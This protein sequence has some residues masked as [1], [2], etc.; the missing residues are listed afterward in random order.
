M[1]CFIMFSNDLNDE[2]CS[3]L[4]CFPFDYLSQIGACVLARLNNQ[5]EYIALYDGIFDKVIEL[6]YVSI[7]RH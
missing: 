7:L 1:Q 3:L 4:V 5:G 6:A 2:Q